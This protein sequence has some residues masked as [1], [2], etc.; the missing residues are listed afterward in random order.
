VTGAVVDTITANGAAVPAVTLTE[1]G[2]L[3]NGAG[4][5]TGLMLQVRFTD[6]L[7]DAPGVIAKLKVATFPALTV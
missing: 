2:K 3:H 5:T 7:N 4:V 1:F 6:P